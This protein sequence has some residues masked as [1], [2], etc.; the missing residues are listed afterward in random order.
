MRI[1]VI[2]DSHNQLPAGLPKRLASADEIWHLGDVCSP[3]TLVEIELLE[4]PMWIVLGNCD[5]YPG[6]PL[7][8]RLNRGGFE[9]HLEHIPPDRT[10]RGVAAV[11]HGHTHVPRDETDL[12][13][14]RWL[15]PG[16][17]TQARY[18]GPC[19]FAWLEFDEDRPGSGFTWEFEWL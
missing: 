7:T 6:W 10:P 19:S 3:G 9:F 4:K 8:R 13:G 15:N 14:V 18:D 2:S 12:L 5:G 1:A 16:S 11:L 17:V